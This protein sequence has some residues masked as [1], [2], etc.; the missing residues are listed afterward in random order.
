MDDLA[1]TLSR[2]RA[3]WM[4]GRAARPHCPDAW[5]DAV[6]DGPQAELALAALAGQ[7]LQAA[8]RPVPPNTL[9][10]RETLPALAL[11][12]MPDELRPRARRLLAA[13]P[14]LI[15]HVLAFLAARGVTMHPFDWLPGK[16]VEGLPPVYAPWVAWVSGAPSQARPAPNPARAD[17]AVL[18][19]ELAAMLELK[20]AGLLRQRKYVGIPPLKTAPQNTRRLAL[21][22]QTPFAKLAEA[23]GVKP[24]DLVQLAPQG[25]EPGIAAYAAMVAA[26]GSPD[27]QRQLLAAM[28]ADEECPLAA[29]RLLTA[30]LDQQHAASL[31]PQIL[32]RET[33]PGFKHALE[34]ANNALGL[35]TLTHITAAPGYELWHQHLAAPE[36]ERQ[37]K[38]AAGAGLAALGLLANAQAAASLLGTCL[39]A[40]LSPADPKLDALQL[41]TALNPE[42]TV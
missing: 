10:A 19:T 30:T 8:F 38:A 36:T 22:A 20:T 1:D 5:L 28:L 33:A 17:T 41:N 16:R 23:L 40:G 29:A 11:P 2:L 13:H 35:A 12:T 7:G 26:T 24:S 37:A 32:R 15:H 18:A 14:W 42:T 21:F 31:L 4:A 6:G 9:T 34:L 3:A 39:A 25:A 27:E